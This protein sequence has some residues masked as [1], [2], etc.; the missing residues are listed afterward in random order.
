MV[1][2]NT[3]HWVLPK[4]LFHQYNLH[5]SGKCTH[6]R[7]KL[8]CAR[9]FY[10]TLNLK[11]LSPGRYLERKPQCHWTLNNTTFVIY[12]RI[13]YYLFPVACV[14]FLLAYVCHKVSRQVRS[15]R[16]ASILFLSS[17]VFKPDHIFSRYDRWC[18][19]KQR[20]W[21]I[22]LSHV[23]VSYSLFIAHDMLCLW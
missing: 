10:S 22:V 1:E 20:A 9:A 21:D 6:Y 4:L 3:K 18:C 7:C 11:P 23:H 19:W 8:S 17:S 12:L 13:H 5:S 14:S 15:V 2:N 16:A